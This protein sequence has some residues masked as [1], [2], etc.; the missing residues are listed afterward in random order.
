M[1]IFNGGIWLAYRNIGIQAYFVYVCMYVCIRVF[2]SRC[3]A[4]CGGRD[5]IGQGGLLVF[6]LRLSFL[7]KYCNAFVLL[8][9]YTHH[10]VVLHV[11][12]LVFE[13]HVHFYYFFG[14]CRVG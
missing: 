8:V 10:V 13:I 9:V 6:R 2:P 11:Y 5:W 14:V 12:D 3:P 4:A 1:C 7:V